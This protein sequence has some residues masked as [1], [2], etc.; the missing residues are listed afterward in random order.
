MG[1]SG[2]EI[3][4][5]SPSSHWQREPGRDR[6][7]HKKSKKSRSSGKPGRERS[8]GKSGH[9]RD[10]KSSSHNKAS[11]E[12]SDVSSEAF[13]EPEQGE[14]TDDSQVS[15][16]EVSPMRHH[17][18]YG[19]KQGPSRERNPNDYHLPPYSKEHP[20][21]VPENRPSRKSKKDRK[22]K[23]HKKEKRRR[24]SLSPSLSASRSPSVNRKRKKKHRR[25]SPSS[26]R[27]PFPEGS[28][29]SSDEMVLP[30]TRERQPERSRYVSSRSDSSK[31]D[32]RPR[33]GSSNR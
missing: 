16:G 4:D 25:R 26:T 5:Q 18:M 22:D 7:S 29:V 19:N 11:V 3:S 28:P 33:Q 10:G 17:A 23:K 20:D 24:K 21:V 14:I 32:R 12:Y 1:S 31:E 6:K 13:S 15:E 2:E 8:S 9:S 27:E 30:I